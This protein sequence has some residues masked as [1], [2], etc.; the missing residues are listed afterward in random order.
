MMRL[1]GASHTNPANPENSAL[2][3]SEAAH[4][5]KVPWRSATPQKRFQ[6]ILEPALRCVSYGV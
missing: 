2:V 6:K 4:Q 3:E 5:G 1:K